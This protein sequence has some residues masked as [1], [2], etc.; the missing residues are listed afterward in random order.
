MDRKAILLNLRQNGKLKG[1]KPC[2]VHLRNNIGKIYNGGNGQFIMTLRDTT[3]YFQKITF[4]FHRLAPKDDFSVNVKRFIEYRID[5]KTGYA[6][7]NFYDNEGR[8]IPIFFQT[9]TKE[10]FSTEENISRI[11]K[12]LSALGIKEEV[13]T[14]EEGNDSEGEG[15][16]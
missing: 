14:N 16:N 11:I 3:L 12:E 8:F 13:I 9:G 1:L 4:L 2:F 10:T 7:L 6:I 15:A 5:R